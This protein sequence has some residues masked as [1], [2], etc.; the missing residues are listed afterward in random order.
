MSWNYDSAI[1]KVKLAVKESHL[2]NQKHIDLSVLI[3]SERPATQ[4]ALAYLKAYVLRGEK[5]ELDLKKDLG[6]A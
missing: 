5:T 3:A 1:E 4:E 2:D 6:I